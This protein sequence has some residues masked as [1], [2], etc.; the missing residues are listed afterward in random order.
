M[1]ALQR[2]YFEQ[3]DFQRK[4]DERKRKAEQKDRQTGGAI[5]GRRRRGPPSSL[6]G[7]PSPGHG[8]R[9]AI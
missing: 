1:L 2:G 7:V 9:I 3:L 6:E 8:S 5:K 4:E